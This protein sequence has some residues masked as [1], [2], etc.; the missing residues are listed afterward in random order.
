MTF[1]SSMTTPRDFLFPYTRLFKIVYG[2]NFSKNLLLKG[3]PHVKKFFNAPPRAEH[4]EVNHFM[5]LLETTLKKFFI[6]LLIKSSREMPSILLKTVSSRVVVVVVVV[7][8]KVPTILNFLYI[9][10]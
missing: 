10:Q 3:R 8:T 4:Y 2:L 6:Q 7:A 1:L 9:F 5:R